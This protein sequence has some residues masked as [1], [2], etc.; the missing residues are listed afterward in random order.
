M[1]G[2]GTLFSII[3][4]FITG[5]AGGLLKT[6]LD[7]WAKKQD[8]ELE[9]LKASLPGTEHVAIAALDAN[10][11]AA[12]IQASLSSKMLDN[13][14]VKYTLGVT[15]AFVALR[16]CLITFDS[17]WWWIRGCVDEQGVRVYGDACSWNIPAIKGI[18]AGAEQQFLLF[19]VV[20]K[21]VDSA[22]RGVMTLLARIVSKNA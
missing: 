18:Y 19:W 13:P 8:V 2:A 21:P 6:A 5:N 11:K 10:V 4:S 20:A 9:K 14:I 17:T 16:F 22:I 7:Y 1:F 3:W 12:A 15:V